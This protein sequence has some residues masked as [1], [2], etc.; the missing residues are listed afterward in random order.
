MDTYNIIANQRASQAENDLE[1]KVESAVHR[2][3]YVYAGF[4]LCS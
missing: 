3:I 1:K 2:R 4:K